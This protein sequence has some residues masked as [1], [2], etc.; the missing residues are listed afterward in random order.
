VC[1]ELHQV[2]EEFQS[3]LIA[4][5]IKQYKDITKEAQSHQGAQLLH[6]DINKKRYILRVLTELFLKGLFQ[7]YKEMF[8]CLNELIVVNSEQPEFLNAAMVI[9]DYLKFYGEQIF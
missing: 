6:K 5:I 4:A 2:Y 7:Q 1:C 3:K 8:S 9:T